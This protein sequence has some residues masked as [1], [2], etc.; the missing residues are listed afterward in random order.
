MHVVSYF[1]IHG[2]KVSLSATITK[3]WRCSYYN[4]EWPLPRLLEIFRAAVLTHMIKLRYIRKNADN[5][6]LLLIIG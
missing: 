4:T 6:K 2:Y 5:L 1:I 3:S